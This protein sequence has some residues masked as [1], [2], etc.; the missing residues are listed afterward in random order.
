MNARFQW[1]DETHAYRPSDYPEATDAHAILGVT[2][3]ATLDEV[4]RAYRQLM[5]RYHPDRVD[6]F[7]IPWTTE[8]AKRINQAYN[9]IRNK[10][11]G[12]L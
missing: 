5:R 4:K 10:Y 1:L 7:M 3:A 11:V 2:E 9:T 6:P 12:S 8:K